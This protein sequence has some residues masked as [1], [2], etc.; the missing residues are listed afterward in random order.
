MN[1]I[2]PR[3]LG[4]RG[5]HSLLLILLLRRPRWQR[6]KWI[7]AEGII[8]RRGSSLDRLEWWG[9]D[10]R[11]AKI[12]LEGHSMGVGH[13]LVGGGSLGHSRGAAKLPE[14]VVD[15]LLALLQPRHG[16]GRLVL[17]RLKGLHP[18][19][20]VHQLLLAVL[21]LDTHSAL[22]AAQ[23]GQ[24]RLRLRY[25]NIRLLQ[26]GLLPC[27]LRRQ[28]G[29]G[30][31]L[32]GHQPL[33]LVERPRVR[34]LLQLDIGDLC[35]GLLASR[36]QSIQLLRC[37]AR[38]CACGWCGR[39]S[40]LGRREGRGRGALG[41][42]F[43]GRGGRRGGLR[44]DCAGW[45]GGCGGGRWCRGSNRSRRRRGCRLAGPKGRRD[46]VVRQLGR[47]LDALDLAANEVHGKREL[48]GI[49]RARL[50]DVHEHPDSGQSR[51]R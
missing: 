2:R 11:R 39:W 33:D 12:L 27:Q 8:P 49:Q 37:S 32:C 50:V 41:R 46:H 17:L 34:R 1:K 44:G 14:T 31:H 6:V 48:L 5:K 18:L 16:A 36:P 15:L 26:P 43:R 9:H 29:I 24:L 4:P 21:K 35:L 30:L 45:R 7:H 28:R 19:Q 25:L 47:D 51:L 13:V 42:C 23:P 3:N 20:Q 40:G 10:R 38:H 22:L